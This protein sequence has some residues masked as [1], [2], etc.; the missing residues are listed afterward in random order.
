MLRL[1]DP[2]QWVGLVEFLHW[3]FFLTQPQKGFV[4]AV[5]SSLPIKVVSLWTP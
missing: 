3:I 2:L 5:L 4:S 1:A